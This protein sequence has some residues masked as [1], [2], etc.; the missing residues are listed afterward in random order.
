M[1]NEIQ[2]KL[3]KIREFDSLIDFARSSLQLDIVLY[4]ASSK[5]PLSAADIAKALGQ[6]K[7]PILD[8]LRK[9]EMK[10]LVKRAGAR[11]DLYELTELG[12]NTIDDLMI[13]L[14]FG[15]MKQMLKNVHRRYGKIRARDM[16]RVVVPVNYLHEVLVALGTSRSSELPLSTLSRIVGISEQ[17]L[18]M[19]LEPYV[20]PKSE[21]RL[22][23]KIRRETWKAKIRNVL[24][25]TRHTEIFY[26][27][28]SLG[29]ETFYRLTTYTKIK[30][31]TLLRCL[32]KFFGNYSP[33]YVIRKI[34]L[35]TLLL[36]SIAFSVVLLFP[37]YS[38]IVLSLWASFQMVLGLL[39][40]I[41][42]K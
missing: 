25:G 3:E 21:I 14:G 31:N 40:F 20:N 13:V 39:I 18:S 29:Q 6:R 41:A 5:A 37:E 32:V 26:R 23:K 27:L 30:S 2:L 7:K 42:Y 15:D 34:S 38:A 19:Y 11:E 10:G 1:L 35:T 16:I 17:R 33:K 8:A 4:L 12:R 9:L 24:F 28:T 22:F 36:A